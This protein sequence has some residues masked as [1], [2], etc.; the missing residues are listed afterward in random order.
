MTSAISESAVSATEQF[1]A[2][3]LGVKLFR[4]VLQSAQAFWPALCARLAMRLFLTPLPP[5]WLHRRAS[6]SDAWKQE[7]W[8]FEQTSLTVY[9]YLSPPLRSYPIQGFETERKHVLLVHGW[10]GDAAQMQPIA[11][12]LA[13][14]GVLPLIVEFPAH[15]MSDGSMSSL[16]QFARAI[17]YVQAKLAERGVALHAVVAHSLGAAAA[18]WC[19]SRGLPIARLVLIAAADAPKGYTQMFAKVF[20]LSESSRAAM[21]ARIEQSEGITMAQFDAAQSA[22]R[23]HVPTL[24]VHDEQ[25]TINRFEG[26]QRFMAHLPDAKLLRT[27]GLGHRKLLKD[28]LVKEYVA[29]WVLL[30]Q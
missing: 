12:T 14:Q 30:N 24:V 10:G 26:A 29:N 23:V 8:R 13:Q 1:Y 20:G 18:A 11:Q 6:W 9:R 27:Q 2:R 5:K 28:A 4:A 16:P 3:S 19:A 15:G 7:Q 22:P 21:Q 25:D 17:D